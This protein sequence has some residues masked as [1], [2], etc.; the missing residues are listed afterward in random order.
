MSQLYSDLLV[1]YNRDIRPLH[2]QSNALKTYVTY[3]VTAL[4][5]FDAVNGRMVTIG[6]LI[7][8]WTD[9][10]MTWNPQDY[11]DIRKI[12]MRKSLVWSPTFAVVNGADA[13]FID[14]MKNDDL[15]ISYSNQGAA[16][17]M[18]SGVMATTCDPDINYYPYDVHKCALQFTTLEPLS[19]VNLYLTTVFLLPGAD[20]NLLWKLDN[21]KM[22]S[23]N[24]QNMNTFIEITLTIRRRPTY[25]MYTIILPVCLLNILNLLAFVLPA[26]SGERISFATTILLTLSVYMT[27]MSDSIPNT[28]D[29][30]PI[31]T[32]SLMIKLLTS[33]LIVLTVIFNANIYRMK[34]TTPIPMWL[35][36]LLCFYKKI[37]IRDSN[38]EHK[39]TEK[40]LESDHPVVSKEIEENIIQDKEK[41]RPF[42]WPEVGRS[43]DYLML[44]I[45]TLI[46]VTETAF[47][48]V[49]ITFQTG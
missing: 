27:M 30:V 38:P 47:N 49:R 34:E 46:I 20:N 5:D 4:N 1:N 45:F 9:E 29:P 32:I 10:M 15:T 6:S 40:D 42:T 3:S 25:I 7:T 26:D 2:N 11:D 17:L 22:H 24:V 48:M 44:G 18:L 41:R 16:T 31:L 13:I 14:G 43:M 12:R 8:A 35:L 21:I 19:E 23:Y 36:R 28:S 39:L 37:K 33:S